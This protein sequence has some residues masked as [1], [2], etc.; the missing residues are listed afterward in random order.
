MSEKLFDGFGTGLDFEKKLIRRGVTSE[1][2]KLG[3]SN[4]VVLDEIAKSFR[5]LKSSDWIDRLLAIE[6]ATH[7]AFFGCSSKLDLMREVLERYG[8]AKIAEWKKLGL[9]V[10]FLPRVDFEQDSDVPAGW[11]I[12]PENW[13]WQ[14]LAAGTLFRRGKDGDLVKTSEVL[15]E[16][17]VVL[18]DTRKK[19]VY[20]NGKQM[21]AK[22]RDYMGR[23]IERL[24]KESKLAR[25]QN[26]SQAS[27]FEISPNEW[28]NHLKAALA[29][30]LGLEAI[31]LRL[32]TTIEAN[33]IPQ[34]YTKMSRKDDGKTNTWCWY[35]EYF[36][37]ASYRLIGGASGGGGLAEVD[38]DSSGDHWG[39][40]AVRPLGV[41]A[42]A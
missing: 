2:F 37:D 36:K 31:Q 7:V 25:C 13:Y 17:I 34:L 10:H 41:L 23:V 1:M 14:Q 27:R 16:G 40:Y 42:T 9:E 11:L 26:G 38:Y 39:N 4:S 19:P 5:A 22:D 24:R 3:A 33:V 21:F 20:D 29:D 35:E 12:K 28:E 32:E 8:Q 18:I 6:K 30:R 15:L